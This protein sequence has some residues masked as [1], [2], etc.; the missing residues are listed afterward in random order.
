MSLGAAAFLVKPVKKDVFLETIRKYVQASPGVVTR[1]LAVDDEAESLSLVQE[2]LSQGGYVPVLARSG[3]EALET[4]A[5]TDVDLVI[6]DLMMPEMS[7]FELILRI[8]ENPRL[9]NLP[10]VVL[11]ARDLTEQ[12]YDLLQ[13]KTTAVFLKS[14]SWKEELL[15]RL[16]SVL[17]PNQ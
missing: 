14:T 2:V 1:I 7:G 9:D 5:R 15:H 16:N 8:K 11:T 10:L 13:R 3:R 4:L 6:I 17:R 12:D